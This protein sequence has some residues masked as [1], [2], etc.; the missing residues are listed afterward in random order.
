MRWNYFQR[1]QNLE[2]VVYMLCSLWCRSK[3]FLTLFSDTRDCSKNNMTPK[4]IFQS[5]SGQNSKFSWSGWFSR[6]H[7]CT[8]MIVSF[9]WLPLLIVREM[10]ARGSFVTCSKASMGLMRVWFMMAARKSAPGFASV[11]SLWIS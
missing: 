3:V 9:V 4:V 11:F 1:C 6:L 5:S 10:V 7:D 2:W 8:M